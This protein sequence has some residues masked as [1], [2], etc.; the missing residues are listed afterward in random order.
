MTRV[1]PGPGFSLASCG[2]KM[3]HLWLYM[4]ISSVFAGSK[5]IRGLLGGGTFQGLFPTEKATG[6]H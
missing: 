3:K 4:G 5:S 1:S 2:V 6:L